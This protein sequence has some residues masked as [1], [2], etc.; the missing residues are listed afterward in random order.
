VAVLAFAVFTLNRTPGLAVSAVAGAGDAVVDGRR[1][2]MNDMKVLRSAVHAGSTIE[3]PQGATVDLAANDVAM[4]E[5]TGGTR[6]T[7]PRMPGR[8][9]GRASACSLSVGEVRL[10]TGRRFKGSELR[11]FTPEGIAEI[12]GTMVSVQRSAVGTCVCVVEGVAHVGVDRAHMEP[13][14]AGSRKVMLADGTT[15]IMPIEPTHRD[16][17][18]EFDRRLGWRMRRGQ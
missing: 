14:P 8:W 5:V 13:V 10:K 15:R 18:L 11:V 4:V 2:A 6:M 7:I 17:V 1:V 3:V 12:T 16:G 9:F